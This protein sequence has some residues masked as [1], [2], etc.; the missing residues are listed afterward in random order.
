MLEIWDFIARDDVLAADQILNQFED[1]AQTLSGFPKLGRERLD[2]A[3]EPLRL[4]PV[5]SYVIVY[6]PESRP[7]EIV[8]ILHLARYIERMLD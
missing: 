5:K 7:L 1:A 8:R 3:D 4:W 6:R 2:L